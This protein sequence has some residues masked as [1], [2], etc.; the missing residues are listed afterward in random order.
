MEAQ[1]IPE[2]QG[3]EVY[4]RVPGGRRRYRKRAGELREA[5]E[6]D[7]AT[8]KEEANGCLKV[9]DTGPPLATATEEL[10]GSFLQ[11]LR[12]YGGEWFWEDL[13]TPDGIEWMPE[14]MSRGG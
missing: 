3:V 10:E 12:N 7:L 8:V 11:P 6:G 5:P 2:E 9:I 1:G 4:G 14:A 13:H